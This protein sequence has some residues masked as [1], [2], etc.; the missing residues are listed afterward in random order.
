MFTWN[1][2]EITYYVTNMMERKHGEKLAPE[3][4]EKCLEAFM[5]FLRVEVLLR[6]GKAR[7][8]KYGVFKR[9]ERGGWY[10]VAF[11]ANKNMRIQNDDSSL[12]DL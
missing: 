3:T 1:K 2:R 11:K 8:W 4:V 6:G 7:L 5:E 12:L 9:C 10:R